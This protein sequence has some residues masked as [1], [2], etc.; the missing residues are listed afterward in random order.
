MRA[1]RGENAD[2]PSPPEAPEEPGGPADPEHGG[3]S[4]GPTIG[5][6]APL[7]NATEMRKSALAEPVCTKVSAGEMTDTMNRYVVV[8]KHYLMTYVKEGSKSG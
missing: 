4:S 7:L 5:H 2:L 6:T 8:N 3:K 1:P